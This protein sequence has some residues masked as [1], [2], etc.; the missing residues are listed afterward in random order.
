MKLEGAQGTLKNQLIVGVIFIIQ[1]LYIP[2]WCQWL[3]FEFTRLALYIVADQLLWAQKC[4]WIV[5][6]DKTD[7]QHLK[8]LNL[9][10]QLLLI[11]L[12][13]AMSLVM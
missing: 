12:T 3:N 7:T 11:V 13:V 4:V 10:L 8:M 6:T 1:L 9:G 5:E 2:Y